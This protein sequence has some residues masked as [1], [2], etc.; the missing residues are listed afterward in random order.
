MECMPVA[1]EFEGYAR[2]CVLLARLADSV[3]L[4][5]QP[6][7]L[8]LHMSRKTDCCFLLPFLPRLH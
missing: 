5:D 3:A 1:K 8:L 4:R 7:Q 2:E 6:I